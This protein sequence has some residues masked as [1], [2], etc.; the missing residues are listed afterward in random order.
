MHSSVCRP[1]C[2]ARSRSRLLPIPYLRGIPTGDFSEALAAL[3]G[4][5]VAGLLASA[6]GP[7]K[8]GWFDEHSAW[9]KRDLSAKRYVY[10][11]ADG[12]HLEARLKD[13]NQCILVLIGATPGQ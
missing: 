13:E 6:V 1:T 5:G 2:A 7:L 11:W 10:I 3:L 8:D 4:R 12:I 9:Q